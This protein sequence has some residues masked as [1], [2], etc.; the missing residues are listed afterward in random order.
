MVAEIVPN[1]SKASSQAV[2]RGTVELSRIIY[3]DGLCG[4]NGLV[5]VGYGKHLRVDHNK[6]EFALGRNHI[7]GIEGFW[8]DAENSLDALS[9]YGSQYL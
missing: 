1:C 4:Y 9:R 5:D 8:G 2:I 3:S 7:N 6:D